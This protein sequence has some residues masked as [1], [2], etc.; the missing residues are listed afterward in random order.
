MSPLV[1]APGFILSQFAH[2]PLELLQ[3]LVDAGALLEWEVWGSS[4]VDGWYLQRFVVQVSKNL[5]KVLLD[6]CRLQVLIRV[7]LVK[8]EGD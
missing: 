3:L 8:L 2:N 4:A 7:I 6:L 1:L 5:L